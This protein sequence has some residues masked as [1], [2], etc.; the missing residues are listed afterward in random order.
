MYNA[1]GSVEYLAPEVITH[2]KYYATK[3]DAW[4]LGITAYAL[5]YG[6]FPY[7][8]DDMVKKRGNL[9][10]TKTKSI[11][12]P[13]NEKTKVSEE[14]REMLSQLLCLDPKKRASVNIVNKLCC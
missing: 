9:F 4:A 13:G 6:E 11:P 12:L 14:F 8:I 1:C 2:Q 10:D 3:N 5:L 7:A